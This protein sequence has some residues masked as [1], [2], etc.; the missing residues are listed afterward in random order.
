MSAGRV[1]RAAGAALFAAL[2]G[3]AGV[4]RQGPG[5]TTTDAVVRVLQD[6]MALALDLSAQLPASRTDAD[7]NP[8]PS[9]LQWR[10][11]DQSVAVVDS[12]GRVTAVGLGRTWIEVSDTRHSDTAIVNTFLR[13]ITIAAGEDVTCA[14]AMGGQAAC[15]GFN[16]YGALGDGQ[17]LDRGVPGLVDGVRRFSTLSV[18]AGSVCALAGTLY[19]WGYNGVGQL[20][21][22]T[23]AERPRPVAVADTLSLD[24]VSLGAGTTTC[25]FEQRTHVAPAGPGG[26][27]T[28]PVLLCWGWNGFG[29]MLDGGGVNPH[30]PKIVDAGKA[31]VTL[32]PGGHH[33][34]GLD[35]AGAAWCWG[36]GDD[37]QL[38]DSST[39]SRLSPVAVAGGHRY[40]MLAA[41]G[42]TFDVITASAY[43]TCGLHAGTAWCWGDNGSHQ[44]GRPSAGSQAAPVSGGLTFTSISAGRRHTCAIATD[45]YAYCWGG[46]LHGQLG[47]AA[48]ADGYSPVRVSG[49]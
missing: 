3:C 28:G 48:A 20:G 9:R 35:L 13:F 42:L 16:A 43:H 34:C 17:H 24:N 37:G 30:R 36:R 11:G 33:L 12:T 10:S 46:N 15:W 6:S 8:A 47:A 40:D 21:D 19:C 49:Q 14:L 31:L 4:D 1:H 32:A 5:P 22:G 45:G 23:I 27:A 41:G 2:A 18:G 44:L 7:G 26:A 38:G 25:A 39:A 29:Q